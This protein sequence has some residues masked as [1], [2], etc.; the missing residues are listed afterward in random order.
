MAFFANLRSLS[1]LNPYFRKYKW[2]L[3]GGLF[4]VVVSNFFAVVPAQLVR[5]AFDVLD[6]N[7]KSYAAESSPDARNI[8]SHTILRS[9]LYYA[10]IIVAMALLKGLFMFFMRQTIIVMSRKIEFDLKNDLYEHLQKLDLAFYRNHNTGDIMARITEDVSRVRMYVGPSIMYGINLLTLLI[11]TVTI[12]VRTSPLLTL[13]VLIPLPILAASI[14]IVN[15]ITYKKST[16]IQA[17]L[18][19]ITTFVQET[20][21][22]IRVVKS[23]ASENSLDKAFSDELNDYRAQSMA[24]VKVNAFFAPLIVL[25]I[26]I[27]TLLA[28]YVGGRIV[29]A[30][31][32]TPGIIAEFLIYVAQLSWP[33]AALGWTTNLVQR[34]AASQARINQIWDISPAITSP[35]PGNE[36]LKGDI[37]LRNVSFQFG[38]ER[39]L[40]LK[41]INLRL[42]AG[43][44]LGIIGPTGSGKSTLVDLLVRAYDAT[45]GEI[46][47][48]GKPL[49]SW[50]L[51][52][53]RDKIGFVPQDDFL[54]S[55]SII[56]NI[57]FGA[58]HAEDKAEQKSFALQVAAFADIKNDVEQFE[59]GFDTL[60]GERGIT[61]S[62]GQKQRLSLARA[63]FKR[64]KILILDDSFSAIDTNTEARIL[65]NLS[66]VVKDVTL[67]IISHRVSTVKHCDNIIV[68]EDGAIT[69][70]GTH[71]ALMSQKGYYNRLAVR[72]QMENKLHETL[73][74]E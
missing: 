44:S 59:N 14:Y 72:Q 63:L 39:P 36:V 17:R 65:K 4:F 25:L 43:S 22:G 46:F 15:S 16:A 5:R 68:L 67:I 24:L 3:L 8:L 38:P 6:L 37:E 11:L 18:S 29:I 35:A 57:M 27:S 69:E 2:L 20:F 47:F 30:G 51:G 70:A 53:V 31:G 60:I 41:N 34:A 62:G 9:I 48:D 21:S 23:F 55:D 32:A 42:P 74:Q 12:M 71:D 73:G 49:K 28:L 7:F 52:Q 26:G 1:R 61:L 40:I 54:F 50:N 64:P 13:W 45:G 58:G 66:R 33:V 10:L 19:A 56:A